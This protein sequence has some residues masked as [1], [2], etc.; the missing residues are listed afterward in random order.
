M[1]GPVRHVA[2]GGAAAWLL[3]GLLGAGCALANEAQPLLDP[4]LEAR[5]QHLEDELR[6]LVWQGQSIAEAD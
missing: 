3:A 2:R 6:C 4:A 5:L 1:R